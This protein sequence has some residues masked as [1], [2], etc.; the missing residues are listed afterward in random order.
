[1][2]V[3]Y[4][5]ETA[6]ERDR[7]RDRLKGS[8]TP[9]RLGWAAS[10]QDLLRQGM[11]DDLTLIVGTDIGPHDRL[12]LVSLASLWPGARVLALGD[13]PPGPLGAPVPLDALSARVLVER[14]TRV[15]PAPA[16]DAP[17]RLDEPATRPRP[18]DL[19]EP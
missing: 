19:E 11:P 7:V 1:M 15:R 13:G 9:L 6:A 4:V 17:L 10:V 12:R 5:G 3:V 18:N 8:R 16:L 2:N 14:A